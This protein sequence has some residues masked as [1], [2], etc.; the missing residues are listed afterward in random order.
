MYIEG[1]S[2]LGGSGD[3]S[4]P[5]RLMHALEQI[6]ILFDCIRR[7]GPKE[8]TFLCQILPI[9]LVDF[10]PAA[11]VINRVICEFI[12]PGQPHQPLLAGVMFKVFNEASREHSKMLQDWVLST[13]PTFTKRSPISHSAWCLSC[14]FLSVP[15]PQIALPTDNASDY[16]LQALFPHL[17][18]RLGCFTP[19][20][21]KL[22]CLVAKEFYSHLEENEQQEKF[23]S[24]FKEAAHPKT[25][26]YC[27]LLQI[28]DI[29]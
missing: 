18:T 13:L 8:A 27:D 4:T 17:Q 19:E 6:S 15:P 12:G 20:D 14:F 21:R 24:A 25:T 1:W 16:W 5:E 23:L 3:A 26:P 7:S 11:D 2:H 9:I 10:F 28:I 22:F 29:N